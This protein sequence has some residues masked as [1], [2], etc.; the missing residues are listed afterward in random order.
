L[1]PAQHC[2]VHVLLKRCLDFLAGSVLRLS[3]LRHGQSYGA[4]RKFLIVKEGDP[5]G[6][7]SSKGVKAKTE[8]KIESWK[9]SPHI[10][11]FMLLDFCLWD[12]RSAG[13][14]NTQGFNVRSQ[15]GHSQVTVR[16]T[17]RSQSGHVKTALN[18]TCAVLN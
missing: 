3:R 8:Q 18:C 16:S 1:H 5:K 13:L 10:P 15:S 6:F 7:Q 12:V 4:K 14:V 2:L 17:V 9:L 11:G